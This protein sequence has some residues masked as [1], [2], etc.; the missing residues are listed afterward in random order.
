MPG[1]AYDPAKIAVERL[2]AKQ[3]GAAPATAPPG[4]AEAQQ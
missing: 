1:A 2:K 4:A 3:G